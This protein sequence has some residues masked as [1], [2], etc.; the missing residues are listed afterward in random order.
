MNIAKLY[1]CI[2]Y[3]SKEHLETTVKNKILFAVAQSK[4]KFLGINP[5]KHVEALYIKNYRTLMK[6]IKD[7]NKWRNVLC[8]WIGRLNIVKMSF[9][10]KLLYRL[11]P[12]PVKSPGRFVV[13]VESLS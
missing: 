9:L 12:F 13:D 8:S 5:A 4:M 7:L 1:I 2:L 10:P 3:T 6:E 11:A